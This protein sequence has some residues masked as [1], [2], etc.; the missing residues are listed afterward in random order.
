MMTIFII[1]VPFFLLFPVLGHTAENSSSL[2]VSDTVGPSAPVNPNTA[3]ISLSDDEPQVPHKK[4]AIDLPYKPTSSKS[5]KKTGAADL[6]VDQ[7]ELTNEEELSIEIPYV[8]SKTPDS[9]GAF[10]PEI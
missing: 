9:I 6:V 1:L 4:P 10:D 3:P 7:E 2:Q 8:P 5:P